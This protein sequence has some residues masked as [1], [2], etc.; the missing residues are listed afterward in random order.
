[1]IRERSIRDRN[2]RD[3]I[4]SIRNVEIKCIAESGWFVDKLVA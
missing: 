2:M 3:M 1:M 4:L